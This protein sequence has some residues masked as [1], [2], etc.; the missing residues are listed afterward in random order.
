M[1]TDKLTKKRRPIDEKIKYLSWIKPYG[2]GRVF[3]VS[4]SHN[5]QSFEDAR[6]LKYYLNGA[7]Y[8]LG[9]LKCNDAPLNN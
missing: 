1:D 5:A 4:P 3:F 6:L 2:R 8:V 7:Q 9:D